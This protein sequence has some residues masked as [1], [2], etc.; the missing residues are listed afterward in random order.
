MTP[1]YIHKHRL[2]P[3]LHIVVS[4]K[5]NRRKKGYVHATQHRHDSGS[6]CPRGR[7][8]H[9]EEEPAIRTISRHS[10][11][12]IPARIIRAPEAG[13]LASDASAESAMM[14]GAKRRTSL[15]MVCA[16]QGMGA[17]RPCIDRST[18]AVILH[19]RPMRVTRSEPGGTIT[20]ARRPDRSVPDR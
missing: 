15:R 13:L 20:V 14:Y 2:Q 17:Q 8:G 19:V 3:T 12:V 6:G 16:P 10:V 1:S 18:Q 7:T 4:R 9:E 11:P 5:G